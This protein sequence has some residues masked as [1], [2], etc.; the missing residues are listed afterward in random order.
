MK[1]LALLVTDGSGASAPDS[2]PEVETQAVSP[3][4]EADVAPAEQAYDEVALVELL[5]CEVAVVT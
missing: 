3:P 2:L 4:C 5:A 1:S